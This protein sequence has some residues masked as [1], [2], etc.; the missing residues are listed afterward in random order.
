MV[1]LISIVAC[2]GAMATECHF[3][4]RDLTSG[5]LPQQVFDEKTHEGDFFLGL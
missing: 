4:L 3:L 2:G 5:G 1:T